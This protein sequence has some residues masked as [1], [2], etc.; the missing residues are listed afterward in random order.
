MATTSNRFTEELIRRLDRREK[1]YKLTEDGNRGEGRLLIKVHPSGLKEFFY[2]Y[3]LNGQDKTIKL[4]RYRQNPNDGGVSLREARDKVAALIRLHK[5][6]GDVKAHQQEERRKSEEAA[7]KERRMQELEARRGTLT[8]LLDGYVNALEQAGKVSAKEADGIFT[9]HIKK[10]FPKLILRK[11]HEITPEDIQTILGRLVQNG[12]KRT[13]NKTRSYLA[14][15]FAWAGKSDLDP[16]RIAE[17]GAVFKLGSNPVLLIPRI[18]EFESARDRVLNEEELRAFWHGLDE[19][20]DMIRTFLR[21]NL[22]L[23]GQRISQLLRAQW[24]DADFDKKR[25]LLRD[26]K[27]RGGVR[28]HLLPLNDY[29]IA[30]LQSALVWRGT[31]SYIFTSDG[32]TALNSSTISHSVTK[33]S[34]Y[35]SEK[36]GYQPFEARDLRRTTETMLASIGIDR[37]VRAQLL[38]HGRT[39]GVQAKHYDRYWY[40]NEK[41][42]ALDKWALKLK[43]LTQ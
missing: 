30:L 21:F 10:P 15:A 16:R 39:T 25:L 6:V 37:E 43:A 26:G 5:D 24:N 29:A 3:R 9:R 23:G 36:F 32:R 1:P 8:Q 42:A 14:A 31:S 2:R 34:R 7:E 27:G 35:L 38:S 19:V 12:A 11:A 4:G 17:S 41:Q 13:V 22:A 33:V 18:G 40:L 20:S 28:D